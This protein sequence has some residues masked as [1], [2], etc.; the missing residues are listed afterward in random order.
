MKHNSKE[1]EVD[2]KSKRH[3]RCSEYTRFM[4]DLFSNRPSIIVLL[5]QLD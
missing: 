5:S 4:D 1:R 2:K 3:A